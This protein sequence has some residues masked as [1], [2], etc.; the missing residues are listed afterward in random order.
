MQVLVVDDHPMIV[1]AVRLALE[2]L[3]PEATV[4]EA[5]RLS[6][7]CRIVV[8]THVDL[9]LLD[10]KLPD[11]QGIA[12]IQRLREAAPELPIAVFSGTAD[13]ETMVQLI[14]AGAIAYVPKAMPRQALMHAL[15]EVISGRG[16]L[17][18][19]LLDDRV[20]PFV[21]PPGASRPGRAGPHD[22]TERQLE[23]L[24]L[25]V[26]GRSNKA[27]CKRLSISENTVKVHVTA[28]F[29]TLGV[30]NR[31]QAVLVAHRSGVRL[32][33]LPE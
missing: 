24:S 32:P 27:I 5:D 18:P 25:M 8:S 3:K 20:V 28:I 15:G 9:A 26:R 19:K 16:Y 2:T 12:S 17:P 14:D 6:E 21:P 23:V 22:L 29:R 11:S 30:S 33:E 4:L 7:A 1:D 10:L 13:P 31:T